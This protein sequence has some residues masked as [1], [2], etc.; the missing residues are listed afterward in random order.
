MTRFVTVAQSITAVG[1]FGPVGMRDMSAEDDRGL[2]QIDSS[3][4]NVFELR[5]F[6]TLNFDFTTNTAIGGW[7]DVTDRM[8]PIGDSSSD[9]VLVAG[10]F[11]KRSP[12]T[13]GTPLD[14][15]G[16]FAF[17]AGYFPAAL[18]FGVET[19]PTSG[20]LDLQFGF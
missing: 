5:V 4:G 2:L 19:A 11:Q 8:R 7:H 16:I 12:A 18:F 14:M 10:K 6:A 13:I 20:H 15:Q 3:L 9:F 1:S 17:D